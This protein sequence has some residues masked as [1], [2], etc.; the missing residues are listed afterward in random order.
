[1]E[2]KIKQVGKIT[3]KELQELKA[4]HGKVFTLSVFYELPDTK[5]VVELYGYLRMP[6]RYEMGMSLAII[7]NNPVQAKEILLTK[8]WL[9][10]DERIKTDD[11]AFYSAIRVLDEFIVARQASLKKN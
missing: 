4:K 1:M 5:E 3:D 8:T 10:G 6:Q 11:D 2:E 9:A 7:D